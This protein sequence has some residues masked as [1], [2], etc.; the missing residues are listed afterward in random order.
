MFTLFVVAALAAPA[1]PGGPTI[2]QHRTL[3]SAC[4]DYAK[5][6]A[7]AVPGTAVAVGRVSIEERF[8]LATGMGVEQ[9]LTTAL[10]R[11]RQGFVDAKSTY[12]VSGE[13]SYQ[14]VA[15]VT[16]PGEN[17]DG[18]QKVAVVR[19]RL[20]DKRTGKEVPA[21]SRTYAVTFLNEMSRLFGV[22][23]Q[24]QSGRTP[25]ETYRAFEKAIATPTAYVN[26]SIVKPVRDSPCFVEVYVP[27]DGKL[28]A[29]PVNLEDGM[30]VVKLAKGD[31]FVVKLNNPTGGDIGARLFY[32]GMDGYHFAAKG[33]DGRPFAQIYHVPPKNALIMMGWTL[34][35]RTWESFRIGAPESVDLPPQRDT[36]WGSITLAISNMRP[37]PDRPGRLLTEAPLEF[38]T[39]R[40]AR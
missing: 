25:A 26:K 15:G 3:P 10:E 27:K 37:N 8:G 24:L 4:D 33:P 35:P 5:V 6:L 16:K 30:A 17:D 1:P 2:D 29:P 38:V 12:E 36:K 34:T 39:I 20:T 22:T 9:E 28:E 31:R 11:A 7:E 18:T 40:L 13:I 23:A 32:D 14:A 21:G 19:L